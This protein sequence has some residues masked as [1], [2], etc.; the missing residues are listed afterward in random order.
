MAYLTLSLF[1]KVDKYLSNSKGASIT[2]FSTPSVNLSETEILSQELLC[3]YD[4]EKAI[5]ISNLINAIRSEKP[6]SQIVTE[7]IEHKCLI[8]SKIF[9]DAFKLE[10][11]KKRKIHRRITCDFCQK[12]YATRFCLNRH[13]LTVHSSQ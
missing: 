7:K 11:H 1:E 13:V 8:C 12:S 6:E 4:F 10:R 5:D 3:G 2:D 9:S